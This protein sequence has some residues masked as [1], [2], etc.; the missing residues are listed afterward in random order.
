MDKIMIRMRTRFGTI[1]IPVDKFKTQ[2]HSYA[3]K[4]YALALGADQNPVNPRLSY[5]LSFFGKPTPF[6]TGP[7]RCAFTT[8]SAIIFGTY[9]RVKRG[10]YRSE[11]KLITTEPNTLE[12]GELTKLFRDF[13]EDQ[14]R[15]RPSNYLWSH[16]RWKWEFDQTKHGNL[17]IQ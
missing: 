12:R 8:N 3:N 17:Y 6:V 16:R 14:I 11:L 13:L 15:L 4:R 9:Y 1:V 7:E 10:Y 5:W 2:F